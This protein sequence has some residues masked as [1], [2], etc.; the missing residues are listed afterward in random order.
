MAKGAPAVP[1]N[2][3]PCASDR[4]EALVRSPSQPATVAKNQ[5]PATRASPTSHVATRIVPRSS[6][7]PDAMLCAVSLPRG[8]GP[9]A[10]SAPNMST[11]KATPLAG[12]ALLYDLSIIDA[13]QNRTVAQHTD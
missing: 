2:A 8:G 11:T 12:A 3:P 6:A 7:R 10:N 9:G 5:T 1:A 13:S 4:S